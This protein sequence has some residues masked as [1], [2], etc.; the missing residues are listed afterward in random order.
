MTSKEYISGV[1]FLVP[2]GMRIV[3]LF[4]TWVV[5]AI[6]TAFAVSVVGRVLSSNPTASMRISAVIQDVFM[7]IL[8]A[9]AT[10]MIIT[11][12]PARLLGLNSLPTL[13]QTILA[14][15]LLIVSTPLMSWII[16]LNSEIH[17]PE[18]LSGLESSLRAMEENAEAVVALMLG[19]G[20]VANLI[21]NV[22]IIGVFA[23]LAEELFFRGALQRLLFGGGLSPHVAIW[24]AAFIFSA[25]HFQFFG[26]IPRLLLGATF[27]YLLW[28]SGSVW[29]PILIHVLNNSSYILL[30]AFT[31]S[32]DPMAEEPISWVA[33]LISGI[34]TVLVF[35]ALF[36]T[37]CQEEAKTF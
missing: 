9:I 19:K 18:S 14:V 37:S 4:L 26:F 29:L 10:A 17:F 15:L 20:G 28:W 22:L 11:R 5:G 23:G 6:I 36:R 30:M 27:G 13:R 1:K 24:V 35:M 31:G 2:S 33:I 12:Q 21:L 8:P 16:K 34:F 25:L 7:F 3:L 32:G